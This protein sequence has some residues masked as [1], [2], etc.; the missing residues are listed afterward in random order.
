[1]ECGSWCVYY[2]SRGVSGACTNCS[3]YVNNDVKPRFEFGRMNVFELAQKLAEK[4]EQERRNQIP[5]LS[6][7]P[8]CHKLAL[9]Y[10]AIGD[11]FSCLVIECKYTIASGTA[12]YRAILLKIYGDSE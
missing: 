2:T 3:A 4:R 9:F 12:E 11:N 6:S 5:Q 10:D 1:M 7:C 8:N